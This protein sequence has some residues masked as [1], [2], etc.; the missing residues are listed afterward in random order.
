M[1]GQAPCFVKVDAQ[2]YD[3]LKEITKGTIFSPND[4][5]DQCI[6]FAVV[7]K[8]ELA[9]RGVKRYVRAKKTAHE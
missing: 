7:W 3:L 4:A 2:T 9:R 6:R 5:A 8:K 1:K